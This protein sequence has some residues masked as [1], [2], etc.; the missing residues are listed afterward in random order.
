MWNDDQFRSKARLC[1]DQYITL[2]RWAFGKEALA[3]GYDGG[4]EIEDALK[5]YHVALKNERRMLLLGDQ[6]I[7]EN[8][9]LMFNFG[10]ASAF[11]VE[12]KQQ[13]MIDKLDAQRRLN[14]Q[15][16]GLAREN[17]QGQR[18]AVKSFVPAAPVAGSGSILGDKKW[19]GLM[20][21]SFILGGAHARMEFILALQDFDQFDQER[22]KTRQASSAADQVPEDY[23]Q[24]WKLYL[25]GNPEILW[26]GTY[27]CPRV[28][29]RE[30]I[31]L[32]T[33][34]YFPKFNRGQLGF[35]P[36]YGTENAD[37]QKYIDALNKAGFIS[38][39]KERILS[40]VSEFLFEDAKALN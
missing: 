31:G 23:Q 22:Q 4:Q 13:G 25:K 9:L 28:F 21:D 18:P 8:E 7:R 15:G 10:A 36:G 6:K 17:A 35:S 14:A 16:A 3:A 34:G 24:K 33:F 29:A 1:W 5:M 27:G 39:V 19:T 38:T 32:E 11:G 2:F 12:D 30:L 40:S 20:N 37:F 26:N